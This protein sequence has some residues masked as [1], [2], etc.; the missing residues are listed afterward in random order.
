MGEMRSEREHRDQL[1]ELQAEQLE[2]M[3]SNL[4]K[5]NAKVDA[6]VSKIGRWETKLGT[7]M[8]IASCLWAAFMAFKDQILNF[9]K[10]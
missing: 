1:L 8:F 4:E 10:G 6:L 7:F 9:I 3:E 2:K 5:T